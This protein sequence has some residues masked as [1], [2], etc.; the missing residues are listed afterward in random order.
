M[1]NGNGIFDIFKDRN[2]LSP[3]LIATIFLSCMRCNSNENE[4]KTTEQSSET[5]PQATIAITAID[6][7][8]IIG[9]D[10]PEVR[11]RATVEGVVSDPNATICVLVHPM[12]S[13]TW[14]VQNLPSPPAKVDEKNW[15]WRTMAFCGTETLGLNEE[16][17]IVALAESKRSICQL[18]KQIK[19]EEFPR[20]L[21]R[22]EIITVRRTRN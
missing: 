3:L 20:D 22:S 17:E 21:P 11:H 2:S 13:D 14:W 6:D 4:M 9:R 12:T 1:K 19:I 15:R 8:P 18:G 7:K 16:F 10:M 5:P